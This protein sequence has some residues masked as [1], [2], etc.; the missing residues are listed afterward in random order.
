MRR[1]TERDGGKRETHRER[2][3]ERER[4]RERERERELNIYVIK[5][6][7]QENINGTVD[8]IRKSAPRI[9]QAWYQKMFF[10]S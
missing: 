2:E 10:L 3:R 1:E 4:Q 6:N 7:F 5:P 9:A 8:P